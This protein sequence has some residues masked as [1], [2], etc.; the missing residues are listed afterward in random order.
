VANDR[1]LLA[2]GGGGL[3]S[4]DLVRTLI[5]PRFSNPVLDDFDDSAVLPS[6]RGRLA[7]TTDSYVVSPVFFRA[8]ISAIW[9]C[10][11]Q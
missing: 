1:I 2:H 6:E 8:A 4:A 11:G 7:F 5:A 9:R 3:L 10:A